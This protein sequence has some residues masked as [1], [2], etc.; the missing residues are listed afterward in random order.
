MMQVYL[1]HFEKPLSHAQ[2]YLGSTKNLPYRLSQHRNGEGSPLVKAVIEAGILVHLA[3]TWEG[4]RDL[5]RKFKRRKN[6]RKL[7][8][9]CQAEK[10][11]ERLFGK[12]I[13]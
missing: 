7:C 13:N 1:L 5:E 9:I 2:H 8:P 10:R 3:G 6:G 11:R 12:Q 4:G